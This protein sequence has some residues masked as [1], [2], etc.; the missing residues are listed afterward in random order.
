MGKWS[1]SSIILELGTRL[2]R[3][4]SFTLLPLYTVE[5]KPLVPNGQEVVLTPGLVWTLWRREK[6]CTVGN[7]TRT[8]SPIVYL[9]SG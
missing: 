1:Y 5:K 6:S 2:R 7:R 3:V 9:Y 8:I 4:I